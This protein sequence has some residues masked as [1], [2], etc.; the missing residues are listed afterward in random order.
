MNKT[1]SYVAKPEDAGKTIEWILR[2]RLHL[3]KRQIRRVKYAPLGIRRVF[4][5]GPAHTPSERE[6]GIAGDQV[7]VKTVVCPNEEIT[8][9]FGDSGESVPPSEGEV[10]I[11]YED[12][13]L[14]F[15]SKPGGLVCHPSSGHFAD[16]LAGRVTY[17][18]HEPIRMI[19]RLDKDTSGVLLLARNALACER[20][21]RHKAASEM[22]RVYLALVR[23][24]LSGNGVIDEPLQR[25]KTP[26]R[27]GKHG[28]P[29]SLMRT[30]GSLTDG[31]GEGPLLP[32]VT[33]YESL[34]V[35]SSGRLS[36][37]KVQIETG[38]MHQ[39][40][41]HMASLGHPLA[42]DELYGEE[43]QGMN[44][45]MLH[46][47]EVS[48]IHPFTGERIAVREE[49]PEDFRSLLGEEAEAALLL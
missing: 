19:G 16:T 6:G 40:R 39:I 17:L 11:L 32:S 49:V 24:A 48:L 23:G 36:L 10:K 5:A 47:Y 7:T 41:C 37:V 28:N 13:D 26:D 22:Q 38:R 44:R 18:Y 43:G 20:L 21:S 12:Q 34:H 15:V 42:G 33:R 1:L 2:E 30:G 25:Y 35:L 4:A 27:I 9:F 3:T 31:R 14:L 46:S 8:V 29:L 45:C